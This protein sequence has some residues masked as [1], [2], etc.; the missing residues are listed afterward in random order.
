ML[1]Y[2]S[3]LLLLI[4]FPE[5]VYSKEDSS[6]TA[7]PFACGRTGYFQCPGELACCPVGFTCEQMTCVTE[8]APAANSVMECAG[9]HGYHL[10]PQSL[11]GVYPYLA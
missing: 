10:C 1:R 6:T 7:I 3:I 4:S 9:R 11:G 8:R 5:N 2:F